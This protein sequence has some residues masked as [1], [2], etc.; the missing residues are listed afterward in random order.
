MLN[1]KIETILK[2]LQC[3]KEPVIFIGLV[4]F[5]LTSFG[6]TSISSC[7]DIEDSASRLACYDEATSTIQSLPVIRLPR[8]SVTSS[9]EAS[10]DAPATSSSRGDDF[11]LE[12]RND[13]GRVAE[14]SY[15]VVAANRNDFT[16]WTIEFE[17]GVK[18]RQVG[19]DKYDI[20]VG[21]TYTIKRG[22]LNSFLLSNSKNN[23]KIRIKR[24]E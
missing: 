22:A 10:N 15:R 19:T 1:I 14:R 2:T 5:S 13:N 3:K 16:G 4:A 11:G 21:E 9:S 7:A 17:N 20:K 18:W 8:A 24:F 6:Q 23:R 12:L